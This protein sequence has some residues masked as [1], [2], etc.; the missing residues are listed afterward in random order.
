MERNEREAHNDEAVEYRA[1]PPPS[2]ER[3]EV[4]RDF[5]QHQRDLEREYENEDQVVHHLLERQQ[6]TEPEEG[7]WEEEM[8]MAEWRQVP[9]GPFLNEERVNVAPRAPVVVPERREVETVR[10]FVL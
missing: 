2:R 3:P 8:G 1:S 7:N 9:H 10:E 6:Q 5:Q 4:S